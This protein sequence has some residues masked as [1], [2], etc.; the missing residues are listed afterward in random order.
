MDLLRDKVGVGA[1]WFAP[2]KKNGCYYITDTGRG[3]HI[4]SVRV[5][6][7]DGYDVRLLVEVTAES[8]II[9]RRPRRDWLQFEAITATPIFKRWAKSWK[10]GET[11]LTPRLPKSLRAIGVEQMRLGCG[12]N[13]RDAWVWVVELV[14]A[15]RVVAKGVGL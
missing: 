2:Y 11:P 13:A 7:R 9:L 3:W 4:N 14:N 10:G 1:Y 6:I 15:P 12:D 5:A 8:A